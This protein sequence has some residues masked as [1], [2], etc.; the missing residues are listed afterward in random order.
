VHEYIFLYITRLSEV[1]QYWKGSRIN[2]NFF[3]TFP[4]LLCV[5]LTQMEIIGGGGGGGGGGGLSLFF[6]PDPNHKQPTHAQNIM[7]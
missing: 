2:L 7:I 4:V 3:G 1:N 5:L 6:S